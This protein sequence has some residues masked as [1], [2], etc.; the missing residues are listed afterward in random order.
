ML[1][2]YSGYQLFLLHSKKM[3]CIR[4]QEKLNTDS[5]SSGN[6]KKIENER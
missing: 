2:S 5:Y 4:T 3:V 1:G 6:T